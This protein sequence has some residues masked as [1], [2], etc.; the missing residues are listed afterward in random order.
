[1]S[2]RFDAF[3]SYSDRDRRVV[4]RIQTFLQRSRK[5]DGNTL[6]VYR[7]KTDI[8]GGALKEELA[9]ALELSDAL[10]VCCSESAARSEWVQK[11]IELFSTRKNPRVAAVLLSGDPAAAVPA[12]LRAHD[13]RIHDLR[14]G[15]AAGMWL[16][17]ARQELIRLAAW[18]SGAQL[19]TLVDWERRRLVRNAI[20]GAV[21][22]SL[23]TFGVYQLAK[24]QR[25]LSPSDISAEL[26]LAWVP[27]DG[28]GEGKTI[29]EA[30]LNTP[31]MR[32]SVIPRSQV[33]SPLP[34]EWP[35][36]VLRRSALGEKATTLTGSLVS[37]SLRSSPS[38]AGVWFQSVRQFSMEATGSLGVLSDA[39]EW[40]GA[41]IEA[42]YGS[43]TLGV[44]PPKIEGVERAQLTKELT[45][46]LRKFYHIDAALL[47]AWSN[48]DYSLTA[49]PISG[50]L[51]IR[52]RNEI[53]GRSRARGARA[54]EHDEDTRQLH[55]LYFAPFVLDPSKTGASSP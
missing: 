50:T 22:I 6:R 24:G 8:R 26:T 40:R 35:V 52:I 41:A 4:G 29:D 32:L 34:T 17:R 18:L 25:P 43:H 2:D 16:P 33:A 28:V 9:Q 55:V 1:M 15:F 37:H 30:M 48:S 12:Y 38:T 3:L 47:E 51:V 39:R 53:A 5:P 49:V 21:A 42:V 7:D 19:S 23:P 13:I 54:S 27:E 36:N 31:Q 44:A 46:D 45:D 10:V 20:G 14:R 11:E